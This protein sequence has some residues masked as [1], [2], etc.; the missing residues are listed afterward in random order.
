MTTLK[1]KRVITPACDVVRL[2]RFLSIIQKL[3]N[4][5]FEEFDKLDENENWIASFLTRE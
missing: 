1:L 5:S 4:L 2:N 3:A